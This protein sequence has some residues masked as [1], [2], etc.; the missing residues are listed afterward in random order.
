MGS[1]KVFLTFHLIVVRDAQSV[2]GRGKMGRL[3]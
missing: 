1:H 3:A 2:N